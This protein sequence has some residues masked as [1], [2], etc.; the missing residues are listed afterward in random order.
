MGAKVFPAE[1]TMPDGAKTNAM[2]LTCKKLRPIKARHRDIGH[3]VLFCEKCGNASWDAMS[4]YHR[5]TRY[6]RK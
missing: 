2:C 5:L 6:Y 4:A 3:M 1:I